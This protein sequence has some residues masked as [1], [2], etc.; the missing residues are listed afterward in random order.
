MF[1]G[2][3]GI[4]CVFCRS[5]PISEIVAAAVSF[6]ASITG[7]Y[8]SVKRIQRINLECCTKVPEEVKRVLADAAKKPTSVPTT[9][10]YWLDSAIVLGMIDNP[11]S[12]RFGRKPSLAYDQNLIGNVLTNSTLTGESIKDFWNNVTT[13]STPTSALAAVAET[14]THNPSSSFSV[15]PFIIATNIPSFS[16]LVVTTVSSTVAP[17]IM[18][19]LTE[20]SIVT[21]SPSITFSA[22]PS[23]SSSTEPSINSSSEPSIDISTEPSIYFSNDPSISNSS[24][25]IIINSTEPSNRFCTEPSTPTISS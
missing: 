11:N 10:Q 1:D 23:I 12:I 18:I 22:K 21:P 13:T 15:V 25:P 6:P 8:E 9:R 3:V 17:R 2:Q 5:F 7:I 4:S 14:T 24:E 20:P 16:L 19:T